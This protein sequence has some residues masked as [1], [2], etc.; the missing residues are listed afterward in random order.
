M[1]KSWSRMDDNEKFQWI[2]KASRKADR[3]SCIEWFEWMHGINR[4]KLDPHNLP[5]ELHSIIGVAVDQLRPQE[6]PADER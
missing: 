5:P 6:P 2:V 3:K 1:N 4:Q